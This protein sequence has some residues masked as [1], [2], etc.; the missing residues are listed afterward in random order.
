M[1][2]LLCYFAMHYYYVMTAFNLLLAIIVKLPWRVFS[3]CH[4]FVYIEAND[5]YTNITG[6][7]CHYTFMLVCDALLIC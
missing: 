6:Q 5:A 2:A 4:V 7:K 1:D 3:A